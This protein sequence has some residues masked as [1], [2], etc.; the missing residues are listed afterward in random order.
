MVAQPLEHLRH[1]LAHLLGAAVLDLYPGSKLAIGPAIEDGFYYDIDFSSAELRGQTWTG[2][3]TYADQK[4]VISDSDLPK[5]EKKMREILKSWEVFEK[6]DVTPDEARKIYNGNQYKTELIN[7]LEK[8][9]QPI[10][11]YYSGPETSIPAKKSL[12]QATSY[13]P[14]AGFLDLCRGGHVEDVK[15]IDPE[16]F[17]LTHIAGAYWRG[18]EK[19][20]MLTRIYGLAFYAKEELDAHLRMLEEA[21]KRD[22]RKLGKELGLFTIAEEVGPG[23]PLFYPK[24]AILR[25]LVENF[26]TEIQ[27]KRGYM[28][29]WIPHVTK[30]KLY[31]ISGHLEKYDALYPPMHLPDEA[32][33]YIK[34]MNCPHFMMLYKSLP[35]SYRELPIRYVC[36]TT[37]YRYEKSGEL[38]GLTRVR[39]L[40][41]DDC[42]VFATSEQIEKEV[43]LMLD[44]IEETYKVFG[45]NDFHV[46]VSIRDIKT[47]E[48]YIGDSDVWEKSEKILEGLIKNRNW[49]YDIGE[50]EAAFYG[51][52][53]DFIFKDV[54]GRPWQLS[55]VQLD[56]NLPQRF[57]LE[58]VDTDGTKKQPVVIHRAILGSTERFLGILIE[59][60][61]GAFPVWLAPVQVAVLSVSDK[62]SEAAR[63]V[64]QRLKNASI[65]AELNNENETLGKKIRGAELQKIPYL[66]VIGEKEVVSDMVAVRQRG[67][68]DLGQMSVESFIAEVTQEEK[69][70]SL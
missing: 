6:I 64:E 69:A 16:G 68:G 7:E 11:L 43:G 37:N 31:K 20:P 1:S 65:R 17:K 39:S 5:I 10:T 56:M 24:G 25:R 66:A 21:K 40:T 33:Y 60:Y 35:H 51:P 70:K 50:G 19:N 49:K 34:P 67:K 15:E 27:E 42:H 57:G 44:M 22:H 32:D 29:I 52:K 26:I 62:Q 18:S 36:T 59:H 48:K 46:R 8:N 23:L 12:L 54:I 55:T 30:G 9:K 13:K 3:Q 61:A 38:S 47:P 58:Y 4:M 45:F 63:A 28:P 2:M 53:L 14:Q 41:Q